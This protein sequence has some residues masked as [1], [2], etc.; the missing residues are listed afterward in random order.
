MTSQSAS[1][2]TLHPMQDAYFATLRAENPNLAIARVIFSSHDHYRVLLFGTK[3]EKLAKA[4]G[5]LLHN[6]DE[7]PAIGDLVCVEVSTTDH[8]FLPIESLLPRTS[9]LKRQDSRG[10]QEVL[11]ANVD[12]VGLVT[13]FNQDLN[14]RRLERGLTMVNESGAKP[15]I[16]VN[17]SD[18]VSPEVAQLRVADLV[19][20]FPDTPII[21]CCVRNKE[22]V[23]KVSVFFKPGMSVAFLGMS[24]VGKSS[25][26]NLLIGSDRTVTSEIREDDSRGRHTTTHREVFLTN[27]G[28]WIIDN[29]GIRE[30]SFAGDEEALDTTFDD[31]LAFAAKCRFGNCSHTNEPKCGVKEALASGELADDRWENYRKMKRE[32]DYQVKKAGRVKTKGKK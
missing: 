13:S 16:V 18:L 32:H 3:T 7:L 2:W 6:K 9:S 21:P 27:S 1:A 20:R 5:H 25:L 26:I 22:G 23:E 30:F 10:K 11:V 19:G 14:E 8:D 31:I 15:F 24:G 29:P 17:K 4:R 12:Y 28:Y